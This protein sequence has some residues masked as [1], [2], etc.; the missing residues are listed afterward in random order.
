M[1]AKKMPQERLHIRFAQERDLVKVDLI[2]RSCFEGDLLSHRSLRNLLLRG[3]CSFFVAEMDQAVIGYAISLYRRGS[4]LARLYSIAVAS[5]YRGQGV[6]GRLLDAAEHEAQSRGCNTMRLE[7]RSDNIQALGLY[8]GRGYRRLGSR[9]GYYEDG[10]SAE[11]LER[12]L[13]HPE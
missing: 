8:Q 12:T 13:V 7:V 2:E 9:D 4:S 5:G 3:N 10:E 11:C 6:A 1:A